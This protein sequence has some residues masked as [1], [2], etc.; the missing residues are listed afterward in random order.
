MLLKR[1]IDTRQIVSSKASLRLLKAR[2]RLFQITLVS[3]KDAARLLKSSSVSPQK[4]HPVSSKHS[5]VSSKASRVSSK[6]APCLL[7]TLTGLLK[8]SRVKSHI[9]LPIRYRGADT[10]SVPGTPS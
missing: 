5:S 6:V 3:S 2:S 4:P 9:P 1:Q 7:K 10:D 8:S